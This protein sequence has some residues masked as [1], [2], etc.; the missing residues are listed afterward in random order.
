MEPQLYQ[1]A[2]GSDQNV[3]VLL[4]YIFDVIV[5]LQIFILLNALLICT[6]HIL[7]YVVTLSSLEKIANQ[8]YLIV[9]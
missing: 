6:K 9:S 5:T 7:Q 8:S 1:L 4:V 3:S 2:K